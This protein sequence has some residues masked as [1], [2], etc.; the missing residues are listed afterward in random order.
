MADFD[1]DPIDRAG[2]LLS[3]FRITAELNHIFREQETSDYGVDGHVETRD[4]GNPTGRLIGL[5]IKTG[6]SYFDNE[7]DDGWIFRPEDR[8]IR[9]WLA[10]SLPMYLLLVDLDAR[11]IYWQVLNEST[12]LAGKRGGRYV[13]VPKA[14]TLSTVSEYWQQSASD[15][16]RYALERYSENL[17][18]LP[19]SVAR[20]IR[21]REQSSPIAAAWLAAH[22]AQSR[23]APEL[24]VRT[25][26]TNKP[27]WLLEL[28]SDGWIAVGN[29][30]VH[31]ALGFEAVEA[32]DFARELEPTRSGQLAFSA[33][34]AM[35]DEDLAAAA[36]YFVEAKDAEDSPQLGWLGVELVRIW[37]GENSSS[38]PELN[39]RL[40]AAPDHVSI[41]SFQA[42]RSSAA[43]KLDE[44]IALLER[45][46]AVDPDNDQILTALASELQKRSQTSARRS[47]DVSRALKLAKAAVDQLHRW[48]GP[49]VDALVAL[50]QVLL[51]QHNFS[52]IL[53]RALPPPVGQAMPDEA[54]SPEVITTAALAADELGLQ[55]LVTQL[56]EQLGDGVQQDFLRA[57]LTSSER[58]PAEERKQMWE[59]IVDTLDVAHPRELVIGVTRLARFGIDRTTKIDELVRTHAISGEKR[60]LI[61]TIASAAS[62]P[63][64]Q[65]PALRALANDDQTAAQ[66]L[67]QILDDAGRTD[68]AIQVAAEAARR[69]REPRFS[70]MQAEMLCR[71]D[72]YTDAKHVIESALVNPML[73][74][75]MRPDT[76]AMLARV[77]ARSQDWDQIEQHCEAALKD[78]SPS[79]R[80]GFLAWLLVESQMRQR[81]HVRAVESIEKFQLEPE[82]PGEVR[83]WAAA[84][85]SRQLDEEIATKLLD[86]AERFADDVDLSSDLLTNVIS[87]T[88]DEGD[89]SQSGPYDERVPLPDVIRRRAF[90]AMEAHIDT[91]GSASRIQRIRFENVNELVDVLRGQLEPMQR[92]IAEIA[93]QVLQGK[94]PLGV[95]ASAT[96]KSVAYLLATR[97]LGLYVASSFLEPDCASDDLG[98]AAAMT[99][100]VVIDTS[101]LMI[102]SLIGDFSALRGQFQLLLL[103][104]ACID[105]FE[106]AR[107]DM[108]GLAASS[109]HLGWDPGHRRPVYAAPDLDHQLESIRRLKVLELAMQHISATPV[110][111]LTTFAELAGTDG[112]DAAWLAPVELAK[113]RNLVLW[114]DDVALRKLARSVGVRAFG[115]VSLLEHLADTAVSSMAG[116]DQEAFEGLL[117][118]RRSDVA[119]AVKV[120]VVDL[121][122]EIDHLIEI[123]TAENFPIGLA[124]CTVGRAAWWVWSQ[125]R[126]QDINKLLG[127]ITD[128]ATSRSWRTV[129]MEGAAS[130]S[131]WNPTQAGGLVAATAIAGRGLTPD[132]SE[133][134]E[135]VKVGEQVAERHEAAS[136]S[137]AF[138]K[139]AL[140]LEELGSINGA[141]DLIAALSETR[142]SQP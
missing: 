97:S 91:H 69:L 26:I 121:P 13:L 11:E 8:H 28:E 73:S 130:L 108:D 65:L 133:V 70:L 18:H 100:E 12:I 33:G 67:I 20:K 107:G 42:N 84:V 122:I 99:N 109:G 27:N 92:S 94:L 85:T 10:H 110:D 82:S 62:D 76:H 119:R 2:V 98:V 89:D 16:G 49:S 39:T 40:L 131:P 50:L 22:L 4:N 9:Y 17:N 93:R 112:S 113:A 71:N 55:D 88:R 15:V 23:T 51:G 58:L 103:P 116:D 115:T 101:A 36:R 78:G 48:A 37:G 129:A 126:Y 90:E 117:Q 127:A 141:E 21:Q 128:S 3:G 125:S 24:A 135:S 30:A 34:V 114:S 140:A 25:L 87:R 68:E 19:P 105:D 44:A 124:E 63:D 118:D 96:H 74:D 29:Y 83:V 80:S 75:S 45:A 142:G 77:A 35:L 139:V 66:S 72:S 46:L 1:R 111:E 81:A 47:D 120:G 61:K 138:P 41:L 79:T 32:Y 95:L 104:Q 59:R 64:S 6:S 38:D 53:D 106:L 86:F 56:L 123:A 57:S 136:P 132:P 52:E 137:T 14:H 60:D 134:A 43:G 102:A 31:H 54:G 7:R 5:Q